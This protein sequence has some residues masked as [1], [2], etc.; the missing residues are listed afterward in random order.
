MTSIVRTL[1]ELRQI[2]TDWRKAGHSIA[3]VPTM[4][5]LHAGHLDLVRAAT[6]K[7][8]KVIT[9]IFVNP[10]QF[11]AHED[12]GRYPRTEAADLEMLAQVGCNLL[13]APSVETIYPDGFS[14]Q[15]LVNGITARLEGTFRPQFFGGVTTVVAKLFIQTTPDF[16]FFGEKDWQ[17]LQVVTTMARDLD[18]GLTIIGVSTRRETDGLAMSSR[19]AYLSPEERAIAPALKLALET[20]FNAITVH[21]E[22]SIEATGKARATL[23]AAGFKSVDYLEACHAQ[24]LEPW[25]RGDPLRMLAAAWL[26]KTRLIDNWGG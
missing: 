15:V 25:L 12:L 3:L 17:Q 19:N 22:S 14:T 4:G 7:A 5:A 23:L 2:V 20:A 10:A 1:K 11:A 26:G 9:T 16:A 18:M 24:T 8:D 6:A 13:Y 21:S